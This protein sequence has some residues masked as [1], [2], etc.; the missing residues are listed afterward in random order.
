V[1]ADKFR[2]SIATLIAHQLGAIGIGVEVQSYEWGTFFFDVRSGNFEMATLQWVDTS[3]P[4]LYHYI[5]H[6]DS[7]PASEPPFSGGNRGGYSNPEVDAL[8]ETGRRTLDVEARSEIYRRIQRI[9]AEEVPYVSLWHE[10]NFVIT[11]RGVVGYEMT[12]NARFRYLTRTRLV[13]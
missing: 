12:P 3:E 1:S 7:I 8:I 10:D 5:F 6:S 13:D 4:D 9:L 11:N 2:R